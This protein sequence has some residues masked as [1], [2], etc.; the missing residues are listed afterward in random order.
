MASVHLGHDRELDRRV[1]VKLLSERVAGDDPLRRRFLRE[2][3]LAARLSHPNVVSVYDAGEDG[4]VPYIVMEYV[5]GETVADL[6]R[7]RGRLSPDEAVEIVVQACAGLEHAHRAGLVHRDVKPQ[8]LLVTA[9]GTVKVADFG[10][11]RASESTRLTEAGTVL[12]TAAYLAP[13]QAA[14]GEI[15]PATDVYSLGAVLYELL[16]GR[17]PYVVESLADL[18]VPR[19]P[20][21]VDGLPPELGRAVLHALA[22][23]PADRPA[24]AAGFAGELR[25]TL[26][27]PTVPLATP[28]RA[29]RRGRTIAALAAALVLVVV[30]LVLGLTLSSGGGSKPAPAQ[31]VEPLQ[32]SPDPATQARELAA[33]LRRY[34]R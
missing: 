25:T 16:T 29:R 7:R 17:P 22:P 6:L 32:R 24:S 5:E 33:W 31:R 23:D 12:G 20:P 3:R 13:E 30:G 26:E 11:A 8:N 9:E 21:S 1:A 14:G 2:S 28:Y 15:T 4:G 19:R 27:A 18:A 10:I 34:S